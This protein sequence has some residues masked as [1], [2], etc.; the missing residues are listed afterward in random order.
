MEVKVCCIR[1]LDE[2]RTAIKAGADAIGFVGI[3]PPTPRTI[4]DELIHSITQEVSRSIATVLLTASTRAEVISNQ[5]QRTITSS[6]QLSAK[7]ETEELR[8]LAETE[9]EVTRIKVVHVEG[10]EALKAIDQ[11]AD[12]VDIFLLDSGSPNAASPV[13]GGTGQQHDWRVSAEFVKASPL[14]VFLAGG[15]TP[16]NVTKAIDQVRPAGVDLCSGLRTGDRLDYSKLAAFM[17]AIQT[18]DSVN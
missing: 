7:L 6:V 9:P 13:Y 18:V 15:L 1:S 3:H 17:N 10:S 14:P 8:K 5:L 11:Y 12:A 4:A 16:Q 2:A